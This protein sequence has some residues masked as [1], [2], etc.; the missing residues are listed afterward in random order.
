MRI[1]RPR[2]DYVPSEAGEKTE[3]VA[4]YAKILSDS[5]IRWANAGK[6]EEIDTSGIWEE[7]NG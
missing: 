6:K 3:M 2:V 1:S 7:L 4:D 5:Y